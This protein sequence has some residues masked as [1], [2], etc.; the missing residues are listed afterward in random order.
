VSAADGSNATTTVTDLPAGSGV[1]GVT[2]S[3]GSSA[4]LTID[5][6]TCPRYQGVRVKLRKLT[7]HRL[8]IVLD[9]TRNAAATRFR[10]EVGTAKAP[11]V[12]AAA[13]T[14]RLRVRL[15]RVTRVRVYVDGHLVAHARVRP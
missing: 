7:H 5:V 9:N 12:V 3:D 15:Y 11:H 6:P 4:A 1:V 10:V 2:G 14:T 8:R 13:D